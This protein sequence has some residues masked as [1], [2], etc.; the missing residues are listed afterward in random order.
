[1]QD[2]EKI[3]KIRKQS[4]KVFCASCQYYR[5]RGLCTHPMHTK[6]RRVEDTWK[7][8]GCEI[9]AYGR[10]AQHNYA[11][12]CKLWQ[13]KSCGKTQ[14]SIR[15]KFEPIPNIII[16]TAIITWMIYASAVAIKALFQ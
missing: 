8:P 11:N 2:N 16:E 13:Q 12:D 1:M 7:S 4:E 5:S 14:Q 6:S 15:L 3:V 10:C 9:T